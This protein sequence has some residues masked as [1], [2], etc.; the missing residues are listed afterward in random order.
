MCL[1]DDKRNIPR[2]YTL[3]TLADASSARGCSWS[4]CT[5]GACWTSCCNSS[6]RSSC[7]PSSSSRCTCGQ[8]LPT[9]RKLDSSWTF[10]SDLH[11][12]G[13]SIY[14]TSGTGRTDVCEYST[15]VSCARP[16]R[17]LGMETVKRKNSCWRYRASRVADAELNAK[18]KSRL[19]RLFQV[20]HNLQAGLFL[21]S[22]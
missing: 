13:H 8:H 21:A 7:W 4:A 6:R 12:A 10:C 2:T 15:D 17:S 19:N 14:H 5:C 11:G 22:L 3:G 1:G 9:S 16:C 18:L 20:E